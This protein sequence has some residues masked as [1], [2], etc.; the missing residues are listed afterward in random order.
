L[1]NCFHAWHDC[2]LLVQE[3]LAEVGIVSRAVEILRGT[4]RARDP[5]MMQLN[6][7][8]ERECPIE[9]AQQ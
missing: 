4:P 5:A 6:L 3:E 1:P 9:T 8:G 2:I 7:A